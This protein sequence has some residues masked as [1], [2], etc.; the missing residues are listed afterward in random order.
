VDADSGT[1]V[2][3]IG[4]LQL[5]HGTVLIKELDR[6]FISDGGADKV[7]VFSLQTLR[8]IGEVKTGGNPDCVI[9]D[10][11]LSAYLHVQRQ[12]AQLHCDQPFRR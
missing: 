11:M 9:Y 6:G 5:A 3:D 7:I 1:W 10:P 2:A 8:R 12:N 4:N